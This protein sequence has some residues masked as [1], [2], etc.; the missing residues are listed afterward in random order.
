MDVL[1]F[2]AAC[3]IVAIHFSCAG[4]NLEYTEI[5]SFNIL[6]KIMV[7]ICAA[8]VPLFFLVNGSL[9]LNKDYNHKKIS[10]K[11][12]RLLIQFIFLVLHNHFYYG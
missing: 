10:K 1:K 2:I 6:K 5:L 7:D 3:M 8:R 4:I 11:I 12:A 9:I